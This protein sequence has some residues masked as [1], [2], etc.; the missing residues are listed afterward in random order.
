VNGVVERFG[1]VARE[2]CLRLLVVFDRLASIE[3]ALPTYSRYFSLALS[4]SRASSDSIVCFR[5]CLFISR[6]L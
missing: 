5:I 3:R 2:L 4:R 6:P 1:Q